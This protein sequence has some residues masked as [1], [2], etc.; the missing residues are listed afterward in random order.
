MSISESDCKQ[1]DSINQ[2]LLLQRMG[3]YQLRALD[4]LDKDRNIL[5]NWEF[6]APMHNDFYSNVWQNVQSR[7]ISYTQRFGPLIVFSGSIFDYDYNGLADDISTA[8]NGSSKRYGFNEAVIPTHYYRIVIRCDG[9]W[10]FPLVHPV[11]S[12]QGVLEPLSFILPNEPKID[13]CMDFDNHL[14][15]HMGRIRDV[16]LLTGIEFF[17]VTSSSDLFHKTASLWS[18]ITDE[19]W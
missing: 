8:K 15:M 17:P 14:R 4:D 11:Q 2:K 12:C 1:F 6:Q 18:R 7:T 5:A 16:E 9:L 3:M 13:N 19:F 10:T